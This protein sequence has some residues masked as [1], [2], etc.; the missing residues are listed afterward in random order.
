MGNVRLVASCARCVL[1]LIGLS[2]CALPALAA[3]PV[4]SGA[5]PRLFMSADQIAGY[6]KNA[7]TKGS[8]AQ[9]LIS[10]CQA[11]ID[12]P[13]D[14]TE[15][16]G[17]DG[18]TWPAAA[19][20]CAFAYRVTSDSKYLT[21]AITYLRAALEDDQK[22]G[23]K[24]GCVAGVNANWRSWDGNP[25]APPIIL[26]VTH[27]TGYPMR[28]YGP[29]VALVYDWLSGAPGVE[30]A[31]LEQTRACLG[32]WSDFY[33]KQ[34]Y[35]HDQA[36]AN[37]NAGFIIGKALTAIAIGADGGADGHLW[38][39]IVD[40]QFQKLLIGEG[41]AG[42]SGEIGTAAG[43]LVGGDWAEGWQYG[44]LSVLEYAVAARALE[45]H[46][47]SLPEM[48]A[49]TNS[50][51]V[52]Y[53]HG[54]VP[55]L[56][57]QW[58]GGDFDDEQV[59]QSP[60]VN[61]LDAV[62]AGP[63]SDTAA[64]FAAGMKQKQSLAGGSYFYNALAELRA[65]SPL[66]Y[67]A[68]TPAPSLWYVA[69]GTRVLYA[70]TAW[71]KSAYFG[72]F[73]S[74][75]R[76]VDD[77][78]HFSASS[79]VF[80]R[81]ADHLIVDPS[82]YGEFASFETNAL[83]ADTD[84]LKGDY[85]A[86]QTPWSEAEL[87]WAR[88]TSDAVYAARADF[89]K[90]FIFSDTPSDIRYA[91]REWVMLPE[92][93]I[94]TIDRVHTADTAHGMYLGFHVNSGGA[95]KLKL[96]GVT[97]SAKIGAS[98]VAI[99]AVRLS[100]GTPAITQPEVGSCSLSCSYP[101]GQCDAARFPVDKYTVKVPGPSALAIHVI[102]G[103]AAGDPPAIVGSLNDDQYDPAPKQNVGVLGAAVFRA[104]KQSYVVAS[105]AADGASPTTMSYGVP[106]ESASRHVVFDAP[107][108]ASGQSTV[109]AAAQGGRCVISISAGPGFAGHPLLFGVAS[110]ADGCTP[111]EDTNV[112]SGEPPKGGGATPIPGTPSGG[113]SG[114][115]Q[116]GAGTSAPATTDSGGCG[117]RVGAAGHDSL[118]MLALC[119]LGCGAAAQ[120]RRSRARRLA[121]AAAS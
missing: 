40:T 70:R 86:T 25:P 37:Y 48:D 120:R 59:Y 103:L 80:S 4:P 100:G 85:A 117:C 36:G 99:H 34:G 78:Q 65:V 2:L 39:E 62:L 14:Y 68:Q 98:E 121:P 19:M 94:V 43:A 109:K 1:P 74:A 18:D 102:D 104:G 32:A 77:H 61:E 75:P 95:G 46:G 64:A 90:A 105:S 60:A 3:P 49:W 83:S 72:V 119:A 89:A 113:A 10:A 30:S 87:T 108:A 55:G 81:G 28:W 29:N 58:V 111:S 15:R 57:G 9:K 33:T 53:V 21:Q 22:L 20:S 8:A 110:A 88:G 16:G 38:N 92:G 42:A 52:R 45:E 23:D 73:T 41:L 76:V 44:P 5:H 50:L 114:N 82:N 84:V 63:A 101:C 7:T 6:A 79:F 115:G 71:D 47:A 106:G 54:T 67:T 17:S 51:A 56:D 66:D 116:A 96:T 112:A 27:D 26:T 118:W 12:K 24:A 107:E 11:T 93:E 97:A 31:L 91:H 35:H 69:R 13:S